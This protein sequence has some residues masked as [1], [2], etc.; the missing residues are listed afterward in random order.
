MSKKVTRPHGEMGD[1]APDRGRNLMLLKPLRSIESWSLAKDTGLVTIRQPK[2][3]SRIE[4]RLAR[5]VNAPRD[6]AHPLD[7]YGSA[8]WQVCDGKHTIEEIARLM[9]AQFHEQF[10]P[11]MPRTLRFV[12]LLARRRLVLIEQPPPR[13]AAER[14]P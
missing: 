12:E 6:I 10:E 3:L 8:I 9:E 11:A 4:T 2:A 5:V 14:R 1:R 13:A 7:V